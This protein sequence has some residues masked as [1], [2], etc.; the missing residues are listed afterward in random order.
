MAADE[1]VLQSLIDA[2]RLNDALEVARKLATHTGATPDLFFNLGWLERRIGSPHAAARAYRT[3]LD[4]GLSKPADALVN[5][6][7]LYA[8]E[9][10]DNGAAKNALQQALLL[11]PG[12][13]PA[14][15]NLGM[16]HENLGDLEAAAD[17]YRTVIGIDPRSALA[18]ARLLKI[19]DVNSDEAGKVAAGSAEILTAPNLPLEDRADLG[20]ALGHLRDRQRR[21]DEAFRHF[22]QAN[23]ASR[24]LA[25]KQNSFGQRQ[26]TALIDKLVDGFSPAGPADGRGSNIIF[27]CGAFRSGS[28]LLEQILGGHHLVTNGGELQL[29][30]RALARH[31]IRSPFTLL[32]AAQST[33]D[34][35]AE[36][37]L[38]DV[39]RLF[40][41]GE[42]ITDKYPDNI[43]YLPLL[44]R[45][46]PGAKIVVTERDPIDNGFSIFATYISTPLGYATS[47][48]DI[49]T[50]LRGIRRLAR[51]AVAAEPAAVYRFVYEDLV[52]SPEATTHAVFSFLGLEW[53]PEVLNFHERTNAVQT[54]S[55]WQVRRKLHSRSVGRSASYGTLLKPLQA[56]LDGGAD[57]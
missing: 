40:P 44:R 2:G 35:V 46:F 42:R 6:G 23:E 41:D 7:S 9:L 4:R 20:F 38:E 28:T 32:D 19:I 22:V 5:L 49:G 15:L 34:R 43:L 30:P 53:Q 50:Y 24:R 3:S 25:P 55:V 14:L 11:Q 13:L 37:Y 33:I 18:R 27:V 12:S 48:P 52:A 56:A 54:E 47:L 29:L 45:L 17:C 26:F 21:F 39:A 57:A 16:V 36:Q 51:E 1:K 31:G 8:D 10:R